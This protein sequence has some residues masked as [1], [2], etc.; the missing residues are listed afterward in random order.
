ML[1]AL[2]LSSLKESLTIFYLSRQRTILLYEIR[3]DKKVPFDHGELTILSTNAPLIKT[4]PPEPTLKSFKFKIKTFEGEFASEGHLKNYLDHVFK[5]IL[6]S[7][8][9]N[10]DV[11]TIFYSTWLC[12][13]KMFKWTYLGPQLLLNAVRSCVTRGRQRC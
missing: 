4:K 12:A 2:L 1:S 7:K 13:Y 11:F 8:N 3:Q 10:F 5:F 6:F 9:I